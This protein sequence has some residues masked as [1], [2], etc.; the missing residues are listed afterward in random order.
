MAFL[1]DIGQFPQQLTYWAKVSDT[2]TGGDVVAAPVVMW[3]RWEDNLEEA[4]S[5]AYKVSGETITSGSAVWTATPLK[6][7]SWVWLGQSVE[8]R[9]QSAGAWQIRKVMATPSVDAEAQEYIAFL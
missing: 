1:D 7:G 9:P 3:C 5:V 6:E 4:L 2:D 8:T